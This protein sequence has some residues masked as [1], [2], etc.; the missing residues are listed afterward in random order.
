MF[1]LC[2]DNHSSFLLFFREY[3]IKL[4]A[5][6]PSFNIVGYAR[7]HLSVSQ[8]RITVVR[9]HSNNRGCSLGLNTRPLVSFVEPN[10]DDLLKPFAQPQQSTSF[11]KIEQM[12]K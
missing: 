5:F 4:K 10:V 6:A 12:L 8:G 7:A 11:N 2:F 9:I 3:S 1:K